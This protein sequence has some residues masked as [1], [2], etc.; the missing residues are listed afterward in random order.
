MQQNETAASTQRTWRPSILSDHCSW[1]KLRDKCKNMASTKHFASNIFSKFPTEGH[2][3]ARV[4]DLYKR[5]SRISLPLISSIESWNHINLTSTSSGFD[6]LWCPPRTAG[7]ID[8]L[9]LYAPLSPHPPLF[10]DFPG[11]CVKPFFSW[12]IL[13]ILLLCFPAG[14]RRSRKGWRRCNNN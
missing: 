8:L 5:L 2:P 1:L 10:V 7:T 6:K 9:W 4:I 12:A 14:D 13:P 11:P 3:E